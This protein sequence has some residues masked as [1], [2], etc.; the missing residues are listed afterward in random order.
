M[1]KLTKRVLLFALLA[2]FG[3]M[4]AV[5]QDLDYNP[6]AKY[7]EE[8]PQLRAAYTS[9]VVHDKTWYEQEQFDYTWTDASG[10]SHTSKFTEK[11]SDPYQIYALLRMAYCN[12]DIPGIKYSAQSGTSV[13]YGAI[14]Y[15]GWGISSSEASIPNE[16]GHTLFMIS[17]KNYNGTNS[18]SISN[19]KSALINYIT[20]NIESVELLTNGMR[21]GSGENEGTVFNI[22]GNYNRFFIIGKGKSWSYN[23]PSANTT[24][25]GLAPFDV[26]FEEYSPTTNTASAPIGDFYAKM[27]AGEMYPV[28]HDCRSVIYFKHYFSMTGQNGTEEKSMTGLNIFIPDNRNVYNSRNYSTSHQPQVGLYNIKLN[29]TAALSA[30][31]NY[32]DVTLNWTSSLDQM[33]K[34]TVPQNYTIYLVLTDEYGTET[35]QKLE[36]TPNPTGATTLTYTVPRAT[37]SYTIN[38]IISGTPSDEN[39]S[40]FFTWSNTASVVIPGTSANEAMALYLNHYESDYKADVERNYY[41]N[42]FNVKNEN[43]VYGITPAMI[44]AGHNKFDIYRYDNGSYGAATVVGHVILSLS[45]STVRYNITYENQD[46]LPGYQLS[47]LGIA[48]NGSLGTYS[49]DAIV[50]M[51]AIFICDQFSAETSDNAQ[52]TRYEYVLRED[53]ENDPI[54]S[55]T[56]V[57]P[58][59]KTASSID[60]FYTLDEVMNDTDAE[61]TTNVLNTNVEMQLSNNPNVYYYTLMRGINTNPDQTISKLQ[62]RTDGSYLEMLGTLGYEGEVFDLEGQ[63]TKVVDR[64]DNAV[65]TG[66]PGEYASYQPVLWTFGN[67]RLKGDG[68]NSYGAPIWKTG[69]GY[70]QIDATKPKNVNYGKWFDENG[71]ECTVYSPLLTI[72]GNVPVIDGVEYEP[73]M[74]RVWR[75]CDDVRGFTVNATTGKYVNDPSADRSSFKL[76]AEEMTDESTTIIGNDGSLDFGATVDTDVNFLVRFYY[77]KKGQS[78]SDKPMYYVVEYIKDWDWTGIDE[79]AVNNEVSKTYY[80]SLGIP[81]QTPYSGINI[82]VTRY[83]NGT[84]TTS[85]VVR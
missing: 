7:F 18:S 5:A 76:V 24:G 6:N 15:Y 43:I 58:V 77:V 70:V 42:L 72:I 23:S 21:I 59:F 14:S 49:N 3:L 60:G 61:L 71:K 28:I 74:Y 83:S 13:Y 27:V 22:S 82:V 44:A 11:A 85:K 75:L 73:F 29:A 54:F 52:P 79:I 8:I 80:N 20:T 66:G 65:V 45:G 46:I 12:K 56:V 30:N 62:H 78:A 40:D 10:V 51:S 48:T 68:D 4:G 63:A 17:L 9:S 2:T 34:E 57:V 25:D 32:C 39:Y 84:T 36:V 50:N 81:S 55:N 16:D 69:I 19:T 31:E 67:D 64:L 26:M 33:A 53:T 37:S 35:Y 41:R 38:Y 47:Q 1:V